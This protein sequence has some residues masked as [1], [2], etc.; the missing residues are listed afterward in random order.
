M[1]K[2]TRRLRPP[3]EIESG[4]LHPQPAVVARYP[5]FFLLLIRITQPRFIY[6]YINTYV[7]MSVRTYNMLSYRQT[8]SSIFVR[9]NL[10]IVA[11][12]YRTPVLLAF[13]VYDNNNINTR[14][15]NNP[16]YS[17]Y[18]NH[19]WVIF[20]P[21]RW[22]YGKGRYNKSVYVSIVVKNCFFFLSRSFTTIG[23]YIRPSK[24]V[25]RSTEWWLC[26]LLLWSEKTH[27]YTTI[28]S[29]SMCPT[30]QNLHKVI[31]FQLGQY[32]SHKNT[33]FCMYA[34]LWVFICYVNV[35]MC[36]KIIASSIVNVNGFSWTYTSS[37]L[38]FNAS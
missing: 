5:F 27:T 34:Y 31:T 19:T 11:L 23:K 25:L 28:M 1:C 30:M 24:T 17:G 13:R 26:S 3:G 2:P 14:H 20:I 29:W 33:Q 4:Q 8:G 6:V 12:L 36:I 32:T 37:E 35:C 18:N 16:L 9:R 7:W 15:Y 10:S 22:S 38:F 21:R